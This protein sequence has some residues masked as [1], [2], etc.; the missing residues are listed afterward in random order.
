[1][2][3]HICIILNIA[4]GVFVCLFVANIKQTKI[5]VTFFFLKTKCIYLCMYLFIW[6]VLGLHC[7]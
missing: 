2:Y 7:C 5:Y 1:M 4:H 6:T 3:I